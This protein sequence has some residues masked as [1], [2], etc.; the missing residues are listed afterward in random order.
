MMVNLVGTA[1]NFLERTRSLKGMDEPI[2]H[3]QVIEL[4]FDVPITY[5]DEECKKVICQLS[6]MRIKNYML[7]FSCVKTAR[8]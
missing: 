2:P 7:C 6:K 3:V 5:E 1:D 8:G 4:P